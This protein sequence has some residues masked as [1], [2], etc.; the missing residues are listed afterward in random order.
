MEIEGRI[1]HANRAKEVLENEAFIEA[2]RSIK[3]EIT[4]QWKESPSRDVE[5]RQSLWVM[6]KLTEKLEATLRTTMETGKLAQLEL[7]HKRTLLERA[8]EL[9]G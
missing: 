1:Y 8:R 2:M 6:L 5:G 9:I 7:E 3:E 4:N